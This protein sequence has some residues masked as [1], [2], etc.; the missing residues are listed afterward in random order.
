[1]TED[2]MTLASLITAGLTEGLFNH[3]GPHRIAGEEYDVASDEQ[4]KALYEN[5]MAP[6][7][8]LILVRRSDGAFF[9]IEVDVTA[10][11]TSPEQRAAHLEY[12]RKM[13]DR[14]RRRRT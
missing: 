11:Q 12:L 3:N 8:P 13:R 6:D 7:L 9:E 1:M 14:E 5:P 10:T 2:T 4:Y